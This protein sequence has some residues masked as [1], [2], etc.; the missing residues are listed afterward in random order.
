[1]PATIADY[2]WWNSFRPQWADGHCVTLVADATPAQVI[3][4][5]G[6]DTVARVHGIDDLM[7]RAFAHW[8]GGGA[9]QLSLI[10]VT[11]IG[12][13]WTL[14]AEVNGF[15]GV[16]TELV[17][18]LTAGR[19][20]VAHFRN[21][22]AVYQFT[23]WHD[24]QLRTDLDLLF[25]TERSGT[26]PDALVEHLQGVG[27]PLGADD[28]VSSVDLSAAAFALAERITGVACTPAMFEEAEFTV[29]MVPMPRG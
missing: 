17:E 29:A 19:T 8:D 14:I 27:V 5:L 15:V 9:P 13:G 24:G 21:I 20:V 4:A 18:P 1:M 16:T 26:E 11:E 10:G 3:A 7:T 6:A 12:R 28:D 23:W 2:Q 22:N 25:P